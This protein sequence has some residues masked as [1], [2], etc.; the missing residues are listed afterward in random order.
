MRIARTSETALAPMP[1]ETFSGT[2]RRRD[3]GRIE[4]LD[5][6]AL[7][8]SFEAGVRTNWHRHTHGQ[9]LFVIEGDGRV[10]T[11]DGEAAAIGVGVDFDFSQLAPAYTRFQLVHLLVEGVSGGLLVAGGVL[12]TIAGRHRLG[13][14]LAYFGLLVALTLA[15]LISFYIR[16]F[17]SIEVALWHL[18]LLGAVIVYR[19]QLRTEVTDD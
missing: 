16:Q 6:T 3:L 2:V 5:G 7:A 15:D 13:W 9:V 10:G 14:T 11:R 17:D 18:L 1:T 4:A 19:D 8:V 12:I